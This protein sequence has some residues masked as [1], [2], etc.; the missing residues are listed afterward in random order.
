MPARPI[1]VI[2]LSYEINMVY[3]MLHLIVWSKLIDVLE[4]LPPSSVQ[5]RS[6]P[7]EP[8][9]SHGPSLNSGLAF[10]IVSPYKQSDLSP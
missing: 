2:T 3:G 8:E 7:W 9:I 5:R 6:S 4:L 10:N 1:Q